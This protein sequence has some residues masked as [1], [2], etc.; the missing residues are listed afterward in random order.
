MFGKCIAYVDLYFITFLKSSKISQQTSIENDQATHMSS[1]NILNEKYPNIK[2][3]VEWIK[4]VVD[5]NMHQGKF[6]GKIFSMSYLSCEQPERLT[7]EAIKLSDT[8]S[9]CIETVS[10]NMDHRSEGNIF[11]LLQLSQMLKLCM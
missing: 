6:F 7:E 4:K 10:N 9:T 5:F 8:Y 3:E 1:I 2:S 11:L